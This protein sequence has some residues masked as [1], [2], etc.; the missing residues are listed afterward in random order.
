M[1]LGDGIQNSPLTS[2][3]FNNIMATVDMGSPNKIAVAVSGGCDSLSLTFLLKEWCNKKDVTL[4]ALTVDH[5]LRDESAQEAARVGTWLKHLD[6]EHHILTWVGHKPS[7]NIQ[8]AARRA[9]YSLLGQWCAD[10][11]VSHLFLAHH[12]N[13]QAETF[14]LRLFRGSGVDGLSAMEAVAK[15]PTESGLVSYPKIYRPLLDVSKD[16][17]ELYLNEKNQKWIED[18][19]NEDRKFARIQIRELLGKTDIDGLNLDKMAATAYRMRRVRSFLD[20]QTEEAESNY[21]VY[22]KLGY[23]SLKCDFYQHVHDEILLRLLSKILKKVGGNSY[24]PRHLKLEQ[25]LDKLKQAE[26]PG[27]TLAGVMVFG[28]GENS[29]I[30]SR[31]I[32]KIPT[33]VNVSKPKQILWD[34]RFIL[35]SSQIDGQIVPISK[36]I[37]NGFFQEHPK[38][39]ERLNVIFD[40]HQL[41][42]RI[43]P[44]LPCIVGLN[45][46]IMLPDVLLNKLALNNLDGFS[47]VF[48]E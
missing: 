7:S 4:V 15:F 30:F 14:L 38:M 34:G 44:S 47:A 31:E 22:D 20:D 5:G 40:D 46:E 29:L 19:S 3:E 6:I 17:L 48:K 11:E 41:R 43:V 18:P 36:N 35:S 42:D 28:S 39:K 45:G 37:I 13:D 25:L 32:N 33:E 9:R 10:N 26:F 8:D 12:K 23:A 1:Q 21:V 27:Q 16:R 24:P 2:G